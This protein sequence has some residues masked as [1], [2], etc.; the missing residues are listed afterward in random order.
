MKIE[1]IQNKIYE[2]RVEKVMLDGKEEEKLQKSKWRKRERIGFK[3]NMD[4]Y[5]N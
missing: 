5:I 2:I 1:I 3:I 4:V